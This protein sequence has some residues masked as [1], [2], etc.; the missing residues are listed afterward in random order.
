[1]SRPLLPVVALAVIG[2]ASD[3]LAQDDPEPK[4]GERS[5]LPEGVILQYGT[6]RPTEKTDK[7][8]RNGEELAT[9]TAV[10]VFPGGKEMIIADTGGKIDVWDVKSGTHL[11]QL[12]KSSPDAI[13]C[14]SISP[15]RRWLACGLAHRPE[16]H[17]W[18]LATG[19]RERVIPV[20]EKDDGRES[21]GVQRVTFGADSK[22]VFASVEYKGVTA[23]EVSTGKKLWRVEGVGYNYATDP[24]GR[25]LGVGMIDQEPPKLAI[26]DVTNGKTLGSMIIEPSWVQ[27]ENGPEYRDASWTVDRAFTPDGARFVTVHGDGT[28]RVW[29][30]QTCREVGRMTWNSNESIIPGGLACSPDGKWIAIREARNTRI[31]EVM[32]GVAVHTVGAHDFPPRDLAF[33]RSGDGLVSNVHP[34]PVLWTLKPKEL[35]KPNE[36]P[37]KLWQ[38]LA[39]DGGPAVYRLQWGLVRDPKIAVELFEP[40]VKVPPEIM[41][42]GRFDE[43]AA[44]LDSKHFAA[45]ES[46]EKELSQAGVLLPVDWLKEVLGKGPSAEVHARINRLLARRDRPDPSEIRQSRAIQVLELAGTTEA[47]DLLKKWSTADGSVL[48]ADAKAALER[49]K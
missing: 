24:R 48:A 43:L 41:A 21:T 49:M 44:G 12:Q 3:L 38:T 20:A 46:A 19:K 42:R 26:I 7:R 31:F 32:S 5:P 30:P 2:L 27:T 29:D 35:A 45:R 9:Q 23:L 8:R 14:I 11:R 36:A 25:W 22:T 4:S 39:S 18:D 16:L 28:A 6:A 10:A 40:R 37:D 17:L 47:R 15:D 34:A 1:M 13:H 33:T